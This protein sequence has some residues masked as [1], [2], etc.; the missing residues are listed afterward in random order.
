MSFLQMHAAHASRVVALH[1][2]EGQDVAPGQLLLELDAPDLVHKR[3]QATRSAHEMT[4]R[5]QRSGTSADHLEE[6]RVAESGL[7]S[8]KADETGVEALLS[9]GKIVAPFAARVLDLNNSLS[10]GRW[11]GPDEPLFLLAGFA[12]DGIEAMVGESDMG[13]IFEAASAVFIPEDPAL[14]HLEAKVEAIDPG[15]QKRLTLPYLASVHGG[16]VAVDEEP[17]TGNLIPRET[18]FRVRLKPTENASLPP[19]AIRGTVRIDADRQSL[20]LSTLRHAMAVMLR[21]SG[22]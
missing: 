4:W 11:L 2:K 19:R 21:E 22:F 16:G 20:L 15:S 10:P 3:D 18:V 1:V 8:S 17:S 12:G 14:P 13:R 6:R 9:Q 5:L 7:E